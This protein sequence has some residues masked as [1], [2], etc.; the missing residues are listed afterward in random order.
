MIHLLQRE[1]RPLIRWRAWK[2]AEESPE[3][4]YPEGRLLRRAKILLER[5]RLLREALE[6]LQ[7]AEAEL[8]NLIEDLTSEPSS[9]FSEELEEV[10]EAEESSG[11]PLGLS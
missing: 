6:T 3:D 7:C 10:E 4:L 9:E 11:A 8:I 5:V 2:V 1:E